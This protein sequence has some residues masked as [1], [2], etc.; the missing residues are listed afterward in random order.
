MPLH[1][2]GFVSRRGLTHPPE[3]PTETTPLTYE[4]VLKYNPN[5]DERGRFSSGGGG[6]RGGTAGPPTT[7]AFGQRL[8]PYRRGD[9]V[10]ITGGGHRVQVHHSS[11]ATALIVPGT[12]GHYVRNA[13]DDWHIVD[14]GHYESAR[15]RGDQLRSY[16][17]LTPPLNPLNPAS[18]ALAASHIGNITSRATNTIPN[19][20]S[21][22]MTRASLKAQAIQRK[23]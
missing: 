18:R 22:I 5:H 9:K 14:T 16:P 4:R 2:T 17:L 10:V 15:V 1:K 19:P 12:Q 21:T 23:G 13:G 8:G 20:I 7:G 3:K 6:R 11:P